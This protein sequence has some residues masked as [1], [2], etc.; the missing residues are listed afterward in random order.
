MAKFPVARILQTFPGVFSQNGYSTANFGKIHVAP[1]IRPGAN[2]EHEIF[3]YH[4]GTG[5]EVNYHRQRR[6]LV[7]VTH[8]KGD[9]LH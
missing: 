8:R 5:G 1:E 9:S 7:A 2:P 3:Q 4:D 6:W